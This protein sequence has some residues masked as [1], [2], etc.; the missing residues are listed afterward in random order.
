MNQPVKREEAG[1]EQPNKEENKEPE[2][3]FALRLGWRHHPPQIQ[4]H[5]SQ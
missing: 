5:P 2:N 1:M 3:Y 4:Q